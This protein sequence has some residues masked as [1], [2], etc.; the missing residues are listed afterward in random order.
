MKKF[1]KL[2]LT[3]LSILIPLVVTVTII[4][5]FVFKVDALF[6]KPVQAVT[7]KSFMGLG[8]ILTLLLI[9]V[10][11]FLATN[12]IGKRIITN[13]ENAI[14]KVPV[15]SVLYTSIKQLRDTLFYQKKRKAFKSVVLLEY[16]SKGIF[17]I[18]FITASA[19]AAIEGVVKKKLKSVF[20][21]TTPNPTSGMY[22]MIPE[23]DLI[24]LNMP[25]DTA[26]KLV[27]S[28]GILSPDFCGKLNAYENKLMNDHMNQKEGDY[29]D[30]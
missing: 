6:R 13:T 9:F 18:G 20:V 23:N 28:G 11:G 12:Y 16:P 25:V 22:V 8:L 30:G 17:T 29:N 2:F 4:V 27:V 26:I 24:Y 10:T 5:W 3:G 21:P 14:L 1:R 15:V 19:P 7:G